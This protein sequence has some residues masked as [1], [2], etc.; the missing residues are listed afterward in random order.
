M[1]RR[2]FKPRPT[3]Q[4]DV[5][6]V[7]FKG[8][9]SYEID[10]NDIKATLIKLAPYSD[11]PADKAP[12]EFSEIVNT[13]NV[14]CNTEYYP[15]LLGVIGEYFPPRDVIPGTVK[16]YMSGC[17]LNPNPCSSVCAGSAPADSDFSLCGEKVVLAVPTEDGHC[18]TPTH[19]PSADRAL[20]YL[21]Y[22]RMEDFPGFSPQDLDRLKE[23]GVREAKLLGND[24]VV[25]TDYLPVGEL[26]RRNEPTPPTIPII[27]PVN[28]VPPVPPQQSCPSCSTYLIWAVII[29]AIIALVLFFLWRRR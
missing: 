19:S 4:V 20:V 27:P 29:I 21:P 9:D 16:A 12:A 5:E 13:V 2:T 14:L 26:K 22:S 8:K 6:K 15:A 1:K 25:F 18:L 17:T 24:D 10:V 11:T 7:Y 28:T 3:S 23:I